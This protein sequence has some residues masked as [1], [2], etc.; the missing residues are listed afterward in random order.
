MIGSALACGLA[1]QGRSIAIVENAMPQPYSV[2]Q[3]PDVRMSALSL[4]TI[5]LLQSLGAWQHVQSMRS[6]PYD[7]LTVWETAQDVS[8]RTSF[9]AS[10]IGEIELGHFVENRITQLALQTALAEFDN[11]TWYTDVSIAAL[12]VDEGHMTLDNGEQLQAQWIIG[13]DGGMS[14]VRQLAQI[15]QTGWQY[16]QQACGIV[17]KLPGSAGHETWQQFR[18]QGPIAF[19]PMYGQYAALIWYDD[20]AT[21]QSLMT[22]NQ[23]AFEQ[24]VRTTF[25]ELVGDFEIQQYAAFPLTRAHANQYVKGRVILAGD[26]AHSI[27]PLAGQGVNIGFKDVK[28]LL[29][30]VSANDNL[31]T[32]HL[33]RDYENSR[34]REN[35][36]MMTTMDAFYV[37]FSNDIAPLKFIRN[38]LLRLADNAGALKNRALRYAVG[39]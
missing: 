37:G 10:E 6:Q 26:A 33:Q 8:Q 9:Y 7:Q 39:L 35:A 17:V 34:R 21:I 5:K 29:D 13:A 36:L 14:R 20:K 15:G 1:K 12:H 32:E 38:G 28:A 27:N 23:S 4:H 22:L 2:E 19:L 24:R 11:I 31:D 18:P 3:P 30:V 16:A 25:G